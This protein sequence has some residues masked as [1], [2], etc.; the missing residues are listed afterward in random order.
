MSKNQP[1]KSMQDLYTENQKTGEIEGDLT[2][3]EIQY[4]HKVD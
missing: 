1:K 4:V 3:G 2:K